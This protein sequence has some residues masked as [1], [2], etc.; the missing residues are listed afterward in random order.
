MRQR[1]AFQGVEFCADFWGRLEMR[2]MRI[3]FV[4]SAAVALGIGSLVWAQESG[5]AKNSPVRE[6]VTADRPTGAAAVKPWEMTQ[7]EKEKL[8]LSMYQRIRV[9]ALMHSHVMDYASGLMDGIG[10]RLT[11]S[12]NVRKANE[13]TRDQFAGM[14][15][16]NAHLEDW[17]EFGL[18]WQQANT[19]MRMTAPDMAVFIAQAA[20]WSPATKG[21]VSGSALWVDIKEEKDFEQYRGKLKGKIV[22]IGEMRDVKPVDKPLFVRDDAEALKKIEDYPPKLESNAPLIKAFLARL[23]LREKIG[24]FL[25]A[26]GAIA[27]ITPSRDGKDNGG[28][29]GT[30]FDDGG[31]GFGRLVYQ[32]GHQNPLPVA[33][34]AIENY[35]RVYR[36]LNA[37]VPVTIELNIDTNFLGKQE[38]GFNTIAEIPGTDPALKDEVVMLGGHLDS[39]ASATG[40]TDN[41]A[42]SVVAMEV[43]RILTTLGVKPRRTIRV[44]LWTGEEQGLFGSEVYVSQHFGVVPRSTDPEQMKLPPYLR[45]AAGPPE[46]KPEQAKIS[47]YFNVDDGSGKLRGIYLQGNAVVG[48]IFAQW[49]EPLADLG[50]TTITLQE[51]GGTDHLSFDAVGVPGFEFIQDP[52]DYS[53]RTHH[54]NMDTYER[55]QEND[56]AEASLVEATFVYDAAMRD[57]MLP[58]KPLGT[59]ARREWKSVMPGGNE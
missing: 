42:G 40:A 46:L 37:G 14:G 15:C 13:W 53:S 29:G 3:L 59:H 25:A 51:N 56:L 5:G 22:L 35:G 8:D 20:P 55:L 9:E 24:S 54:S 21:A 43:M 58:R 19:W 7:P 10:P 57:L 52:L 32:E 6:I 44:A 2:V 11:G 33:V 26:E 12:P 27:A 16:T 47:A 45:E 23:E 50:V 34:A 39:W 28:S 30:I 48:P 49:I 18:G 4:G 41:G 31:A 38:H 17:G 36:L 1:P